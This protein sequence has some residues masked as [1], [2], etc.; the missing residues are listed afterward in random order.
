MGKAVRNRQRTFQH[1]ETE[2]RKKKDEGRTGTKE[3][4]MEKTRK[5]RK[6]TTHPYQQGF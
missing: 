4:R 3:R 1:G 6:S 5:M 2:E